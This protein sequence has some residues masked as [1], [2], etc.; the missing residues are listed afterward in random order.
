[1][2]MDQAPPPQHPAP[3]SGVTST[4]PT[5]SHLDHRPPR[6][7][8]CHPYL[9]R[10]THLPP[11]RRPHRPARPVHHRRRA[12]IPV[13]LGHGHAWPLCVHQRILLQPD[14]RLPPRR[15]SPTVRRR[16]LLCSPSPP[17]HWSST[18]AP[19]LRPQQGS[20]DATCVLKLCDAY[21]VL[22]FA[23]QFPIELCD[24]LL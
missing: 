11:G 4:A 24:A 21:C 19:L 7:R 15:R 16:Q 3:D 13:K 17:C 2:H 12:A 9:H 14:G 22:Y 6:R 18:T 20:S 23:M 1:V 10:P 5:H 8:W